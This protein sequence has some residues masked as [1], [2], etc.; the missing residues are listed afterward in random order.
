[1][2]E[3]DNV[4]SSQA[5]S[6]VDKGGKYFWLNTWWTFIGLNIPLFIILY[7]SLLDS[8]N[9]DGMGGLIIFIPLILV[10]ILETPLIFRIFINSVLGRR[11]FRLEK[12]FVKKSLLVFSACL[13]PSLTLTYNSDTFYT[14]IFFAIFVPWLFLVFNATSAEFGQKHT[15]VKSGLT[16]GGIVISVVLCLFLLI[17]Y[18][19]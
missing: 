17:I 2:I 19:S 7:Y 11:W 14:I 13:I 12:E 1:M 15:Y 16:T 18:N 3:N 5:S 10:C 4:V 6:Q 8:A 9:S